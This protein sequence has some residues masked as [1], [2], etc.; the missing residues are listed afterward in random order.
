MKCPSCGREIPDDSDICPYCTASV[1]HRV[2]MRT[3]YAMAMVL[4][5]LGAAYAVLAY[6]G[7]EIPVT[8]IRDLG[9]KD[10]YNFVRIRGYV[11][12]YPWTYENNYEVTSFRFRVNDGTGTITVKLYSTAI[13]R[14]LEENKI[15]EMGDIVDLKGTYLYSSNSLVINNVDY[16]SIE[17]GEYREVSLDGLASA[18][19]W[20]FKEGEKVYVYGNITG[21]TGYSFGFICSMD[22]KVDMLVPRAYYSLGVV[23]LEKM[24]SGY[25]RTYG[26]LEFYRPKQPSSSYQ[27]VNL[28]DLLNNTE[29]YNG[30]YVRI[31]W[32]QV[33]SKDEDSRTIQVYSNGSQITVYV[34][35][36]VRYYDPGDNVEIQ[37]KF[38][39]YQGTW[40]ISVSSSSDYVSE[41]KWEIIAGPR[42]DVVREKEYEENSTLELFS[43]REIRGKVIDYSVYTYSALLTVW[44]ENGTYTV[45]L[46]SNTMMG[47]IDY[48]KEVVVRGIVTEY[49]GR[50]EI[51]VRPFTQDSV[52]VVG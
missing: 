46:E 16:M 41:P 10:N 36:G 21:V 13:K 24:G 15:P 22:E 17:R 11:D 52:E 38:I 47:N 12:G 3:I 35:D 1:K 34:R 32:A 44:N 7:E 48:G 8:D 45:Y 2:S 5:L 42:F 39:N 25:I 6:Y 18:P 28:P 31:P 27:V 20:E 19:P 33:I 14:M 4:L 26:A 30:T 29:E 51:K 49:Q 50:Y 37:G 43:L 9:L 40:E 23:D